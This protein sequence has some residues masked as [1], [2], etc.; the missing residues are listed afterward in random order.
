MIIN[1]QFLLSHLTVPINVREIRRESELSCIC[2]FGVSIFYD[3]SF[4]FWNCS[5]SV[6]CFVGTV[7]T[8]WYVL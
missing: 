1:Q 6:V 7:P 5:D 8:V 2:V 4:G 3:L